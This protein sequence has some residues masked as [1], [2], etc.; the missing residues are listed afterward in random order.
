MGC[1]KAR[2]NSNDNVIKWKIISKDYLLNCPE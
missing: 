2:L 1:D